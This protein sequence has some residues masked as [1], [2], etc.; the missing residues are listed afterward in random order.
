M[1][2]AHNVALANL[3]N[4]FNNKPTVQAE[5]AGFLATLQASLA[6]KQPLS[7]EE[8]D[9]NLRT[10]GAFVAF[11]AAVAACIAF[12]VMFRTYHLALEKLD[13]LTALFHNP[14]ARVASGDQ[15]KRILK[16]LGVT[17]EE[18]QEQDKQAQLTDALEKVSLLLQAAKGGNTLVQPASNYSPPAI[19]QQTPASNTVSSYQLPSAPQLVQPLLSAPHH[20]YVHPGQFQVTA[21]VLPVPQMVTH[22]PQYHYPTIQ[23]S[24]V[25]ISKPEPIAEPAPVPRQQVAAKSSLESISKPQLIS[26]LL[27]QLAREGDLER[28]V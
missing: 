13:S 5:Q 22:A 2:G 18:D 28:Q 1:G 23:E 21:P 8:Y 9:Q 15:G 25:A 19:I 12:Y 14:N 26:L 4:K 6:A 3:S 7:Q 17:S 10:T 20:P 24:R 11:I 27:Q 16:K